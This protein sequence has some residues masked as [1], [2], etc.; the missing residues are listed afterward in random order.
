MAAVAAAV[1]AA[2]QVSKSLVL[3]AH[4]AGDVGPGWISVRL[5]RNTGAS[6]GLASGYPLLVT[7]AALA[8]T[9]LAAGFALRARGP[10]VAVSLA[11]VLGGAA[12]NL[13]DRL[14]RAPGFGRGGVVDWIHLGGR[15]GSMDVAD[16]AIQLGVLGAII[17][18]LAGERVRKTREARAASETR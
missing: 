1:L 13:A 3:G 10:V 2:D 6:G 5:V 4:P 8:I 7:L 15:G 14:F 16:I 17:A 18:M 9:A 11:A 12:G